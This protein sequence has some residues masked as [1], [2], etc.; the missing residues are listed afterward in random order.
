MI[1]KL[2]F[3]EV[4]NVSGEPVVLDM[5]KFKN[6]NNLKQLYVIEAMNY[7]KRCIYR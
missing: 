5:S 2:S 4:S 7:Y 6:L 1:E 3:C